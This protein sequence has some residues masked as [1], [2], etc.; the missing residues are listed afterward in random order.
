MDGRPG[1]VDGRPRPMGGGGDAAVGQASQALPEGSNMKRWASSALEQH[2]VQ[3]H[4]A[5]SGIRVART[6]SFSRVSGVSRA[7]STLPS[8]SEAAVTSSDAR[9]DTR[10]LLCD[11]YLRRWACHRVNNRRLNLT[12]SLPFAKFSNFHTI[13]SYHCPSPSTLRC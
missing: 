2:Q 3:Q 13:A 1:P 7:T 8:T 4:Q 11:D 6:T 5:R 12:P 10:S 9:C